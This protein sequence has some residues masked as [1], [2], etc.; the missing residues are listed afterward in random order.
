MTQAPP[1]PAGPS[2]SLRPPPWTYAWWTAAGALLGFGVAGL[3]TIGIF[4]LPVGLV[5]VVAGS[6]WQ[7]LQSSSA[8]ASLGGLA[9]APLY[10]AWV[11]REGPGTV[12]ESLAG[13]VTSCAERWSPWPFLAV[14]A[15][16]VAISVAGVLR[17][18]RPSGER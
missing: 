2:T 4:L 18:R 13:E 5:L 1:S 10:L 6:T 3:L 17:T 12:C 9:A 14:A 7:P 15:A 16:L 11:N 8:L